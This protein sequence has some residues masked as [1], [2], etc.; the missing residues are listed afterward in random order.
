MRP[1]IDTLLERADSL[2]GRLEHLL[3]GPAAAPDW[4][5]AAAFR[6][7][8]RGRTHVLEPVRQTSKIRLGQLIEIDM[9]ARISR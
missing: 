8:R 6:F 9:E 1:R 7:R 3:P 4:Q 5:A 2:L